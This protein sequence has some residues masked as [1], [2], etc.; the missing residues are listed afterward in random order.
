MGEVKVASIL[1][2]AIVPVLLF[3]ADAG[4]ER[5]TAFHETIISSFDHF[6]LPGI[7]TYDHDPRY[8]LHNLALGK[9]RI[10]VKLLKG[11]VW[12]Y[13][14]LD[15]KVVQTPEE[16]VVS[17]RVD[18][19][20]I[21]ARLFPMLVGRDGMRWEG[22]AGLCIE[23]DP[24]ARLVV[25]FGAPGRVRI[26]GFGSQL[27]FRWQ[28]L[29][30]PNLAL[31]PPKWEQR[32][33]NIFLTPISETTLYVAARANFP[34][35]VSLDGFWL[36]GEGKNKLYMIVAFSE[37]EERASQLARGDVL[38]EERKLREHYRKL[39]QSAWI[40]TPE[41]VLDEAFRCALWNLEMTWVRPWGWIEAVH[42]WGTLYSQQHSLATDWLGQEDRSREMIMTHAKHILPN[43][44]IPQLDTYGRA[45]VDFGGWNQF[46]VW[47]VQHH[48]RMTSDKEFAKEIYPI[49]SRVINQTFTAHD[50]DGNGLLGFGQQIGNQEDYISTPED[51]TSPT[52]AGIEMLRTKAEIADA[53]GFKEEA[54]IAREKAKWMEERL[55][56]EL[57][58]EELGWFAFYK[59][60]LDVL[61]IEPP[62][63]SLI[64]PVIYNIVD[65]LDSYT[66]LC[67]LKEALQGGQGEIYVSNLFPSYV[68]ATVGS[69]AGGQQQP[70]ATLA[71]SRIGYPEDG[72]APLLWI[73][74]IVTSPPHDGAWPELGIE[75]TRAY[76]S[77]PAGVFIW[78]VIEG[79]F[80]LELN[81]PKS[82]LFLRPG[83]PLQWKSAELHL[84]QFHLVFS[85]R[86]GEIILNISSQEE[87]KRSLRWVLPVV[88]IK[89]VMVNGKRLPF[90]LE[91]LVNRILLVCDV[92]STK[93][94]RLIIKYTP[95]KWEL[96]APKEVV[97]GENFRVKVKGGEVVGVEDR[98]GVAQGWKIRG[99]NEI[100]ICLKRGMGDLREMYG[101]MGRKLFSRR[102]LFLL[103]KAGAV[104]FWASVDLTILP[105]L[106]VEASEER[107]PDGSYGVAVRL[108]N[109][110]SKAI[111]GRSEVD[112]G[113]DEEGKPAIRGTIM[114]DLKGKGE[115]ITL[116]PIPQNA[117]LLPGENVFSLRLPD[118][119]VLSTLLRLHKFFEEFPLPPEKI[120]TVPLQGDILHSDEEWRNF[121]WWSAYGHPPWNALTTPLEGMQKNEISIPSFGGMK[122]SLQGRKLAV[123][124]WQ[125]GRP[126]LNL[127]VNS[128]VRKMYL[129]IVPFLDHQDAYS[130]VGRITA[131]CADG[132]VI[133]KDLYFPGDL[134]WWGPPLI[135]GDFATLGKGW[136]RSYALETPSAI[137]NIVELDL[138]KRR[139]V[140]KIKL[141]TRGRYPALG[142]LSLLGVR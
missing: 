54:K 124:S 103:C 116:L 47:D 104:N 114:L 99:R 42:H 56:E 23:S 18:N 131:V 79:L 126:S 133:K 136:S 138:G 111:N 20:K 105:P 122:F 41:P 45:R 21:T 2:L 48:W 27:P 106:E 100:E 128:D 96:N 52:I 70:W 80:G 73:A 46:F 75:S 19:F 125:L 36:V 86:E 32:E 135:I 68:N 110:S 26:H 3:S 134:D 118:G 34:L 14:G 39:F 82:T 5:M 15:Q 43:G 130:M 33:G 9:W 88:N 1:L 139:S 61:H 129:L 95:I 10:G 97:E 62:Y 77:P 109:N 78:G 83:L 44:M 67:H 31:S 65:P 50:P 101:N 25:E 58:Q 55:K 72:L 91:P 141:E 115:Q 81:K 74:N 8:W 71:F 38:S 49:L 98:Q 76:F 17:A 12:L 93:E 28:Y 35:Q 16:L 40:K 107:F 123:A 84:P 113:V 7:F 121:R 127:E 117:P 30:Q 102:T 64:W 89:E 13:E 29:L 137:M 69:Q 37:D 53:L 92:P 90:K 108:K 4:Q 22:A 11:T 24:E 60:A 66:S 57:W 94:S 85:H 63:H 119:R 59:D 51:G 142:L 120:I 132:A 140:K 112:I 87:F 6:A